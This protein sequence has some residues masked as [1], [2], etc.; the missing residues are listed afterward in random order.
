[1]T[2]RLSGSLPRRD[3]LN[4][5]PHPPARS[6]DDGRAGDLTVTTSTVIITTAAVPVNAC[7]RPPLTPPSD[8]DGA[9]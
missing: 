4:H 5:P 8:E 7:D 1:M 9:M 3:V 6:F 2:D